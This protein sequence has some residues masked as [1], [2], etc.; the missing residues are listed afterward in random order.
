MTLFK[1]ISVLVGGSL[2]IYFMKGLDYSWF[3]EL[4]EIV[5]WII[6]PA[7]VAIILWIVHQMDDG[8]D[9]DAHM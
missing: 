6:I 2:L 9:P 7:G 1:L 5:W 4:P 8:Y 3:K